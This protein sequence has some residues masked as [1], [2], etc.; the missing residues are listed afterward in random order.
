MCAHVCVCVCA[1]SAYNDM[2]ALLKK[3]MDECV[4]LSEEVVKL[5]GQVGLTHVHIHTHT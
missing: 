1:Q 4:R 3:S 5:E 2:K